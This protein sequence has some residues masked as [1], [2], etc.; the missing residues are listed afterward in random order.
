LKEVKA[1][2]NNRIRNGTG[3]QRDWKKRFLLKR[4]ASGGSLFEKY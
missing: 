3:E 1:D 4:S 2:N